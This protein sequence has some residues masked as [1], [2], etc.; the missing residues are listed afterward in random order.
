MDDIS[1]IVFG[2]VPS[3][4][5]GQSLGINNIPPKICSFSCIYCQIGRT[6]EM[7][8]KRREFYNPTELVEAVEKRVRKLKEN[9]E[10]IDYL[11]FVP[12]G[13]PTLDINIGREIEELDDLGI[14]VAVITNASLLWQED[15]RKDLLN[16][17][18]VSL[19]IDAVSPSIWRKIDRPHGFLRL[20]WILKG[21]KEF[22]RMFD[23]ELT[24]ETM[25]VQGTNDHKEELEKIADFISGLKIT[26]S[27]LSIPTRPP[28]EKRVKPANEEALAAAYQIFKERGIDVEY[29]TGFEGTE[30]A[31]T[32]DVKKDL[33]AITSVHPMREDAV[34][35]L[36]KKGGNDWDVVEKLIKEGKL[37][38]V[39]YEGERFY[40]RKLTNISEGKP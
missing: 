36:L 37:V 27:Y 4:R 9:G 33:L 23:G 34:R 17:D 29:L 21:I 22:S 35:E 1:T 2:P 11:S 25:L 26:K 5:L 16:A 39:D 24:T 7:I 19:K 6:R 10:G 40:I 31:F 8:G 28:S 15:V 30:F 12:D 13:E 18:W 38:G 14:K 32:G 3:R 20:K